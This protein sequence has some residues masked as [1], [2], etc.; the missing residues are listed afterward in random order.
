MSIA[1][2]ITDRLTLRAPALRDADAVTA[3][4]QDDAVERWL[5]NP[6]YPYTLK[7]AEDFIGLDHAGTVR[8]IEDDGGLC[9]CVSLRDGLGYWLARDRW[10]RGYMTEAARAVVA[11]RF[12]TSDADIRSG[13]VVGNVASRR[14]LEGL[15]FRDDFVKTVPIAARGEDMNV[16]KMRLT[17]AD[18]AAR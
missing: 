6:P 2:I 12:K 15:G 13:Y 5:T 4:L 14:I 18:W 11:H 17:H 3:V 8:F 9:G 10:G 16:Q 1:D 7:D